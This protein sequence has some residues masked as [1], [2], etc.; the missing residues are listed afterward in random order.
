MKSKLIISIF[1]IT[2]FTPVLALAAIPFRP[3]VGIPGFNG[4]E[5]ISLNLFVNRFFLTC[6]ALA[7]LLAVVKLV[8]AGFKYMMTDVVTSKEDAKNDIKGA[9]FGLLV[10]ASTVLILSTINEK[11]TNFDIVNK[12]SGLISPSANNSGG[13]GG[14]PVQNNTVK[15]VTCANPNDCTPEAKICMASHG[16]VS[17][18]QSSQGKINC[19]TKTTNQTPPG[20]IFKTCN[21]EAQCKQF[22]EDCANSGGTIYDRYTGGETGCYT[23][24]SGGNSGGNNSGGNNNLVHNNNDK[25]TRDVYIS[26]STINTVKKLHD[27]AVANVVDKGGNVVKAVSIGALTNKLQNEIEDSCVASGGTGVSYYTLPS[28]QSTVAGY[29]CYN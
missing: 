4:G 24:S 11:I 17:V 18:Q 1:F 6:I 25:V 26:D 27:A 16:Y 21:P 28:D 13:G 7:A 3:L 22:R 8:I 5:E 15:T 12:Y 29:V 9:L 2:F 20:T 10:V 23:S 14:N 19:V